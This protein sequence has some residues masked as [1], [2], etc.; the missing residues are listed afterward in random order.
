MS[1]SSTSCRTSRLPRLDCVLSVR[2]GLLCIAKLAI[3]NARRGFEVH[4]A[5]GSFQL[6]LQFVDAALEVGDAVGGGQ[7]TVPA[8]LQRALVLLEGGKF[9]FKRGQALAGGVVRFLA[10]ALALDFELHDLAVEF[11]E[12][13]RGR[14]ELHAQAAGGFV[15]GVDGL[16]GQLAVG[17]VAMRQGRGGNQRAVA[18][19]DLVVRLVSVPETAQDRDGV[20]D[21]RF[22]DQNRLKAPFEGGVGL[23]VLAVFVE[24]G[25]ANGMQLAARQ[26]GLEHIGGV[27]GAFGRA[28]ADDGVQFVDEGHDLALGSGDFLQDRLQ[29]LLELTA[30][31][32]AGQHGAEVQR[33]HTLVLQSLG[34]VAAHD[35]LGEAF[36]DG[37]LADAG[38]TEEHGVVLG[39]A[40]QDLD[41]AADF[42]VAPDDRVQLAAV[43]QVGEVD[44]VLGQGVERS[45]RRLRGDAL[46]A[47]HFA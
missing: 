23:H 37:G 9:G 44:G 7:F 45:L 12:F 27:H 31:L 5:G 38:L 4:L 21:R 26:H 3:A 6:G 39:S 1:S 8:G 47:A 15:D 32:G 22:V 10:Q 17:N 28:G 11:V 43:G 34:H 19:L 41:D 18:N 40:A 14:G 42:F 16:V 35:P 20:L 13:R 46:C 36:N 2:Q 33:Q 29:T 25:G 24:R 30:V